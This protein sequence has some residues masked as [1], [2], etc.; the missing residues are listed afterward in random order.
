MRLRNELYKVLNDSYSDE[1]TKFDIELN[2]DHFIY[3]A[4][5]PEEPITP[6]VCLIQIAKELLESCVNHALH[7]EKIKNVKFLSVVSPIDTQ[8]VTYTIGNI[9]KTNENGSIKTQVVVSNENT[10]F[11]KISMTCSYYARSYR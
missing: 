9:I 3:H 5:F 11:A 7:I 2:P 4:H 8:R 1:C 6:G 10:K